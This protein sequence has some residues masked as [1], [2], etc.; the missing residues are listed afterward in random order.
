MGA[1]ATTLARSTM[2]AKVTM[3]ARDDTPDNM[4]DNIP[5]F[6]SKLQVQTSAPNFGSEL[7]LRTLAPNFSSELQPRTSAPNFSSQLQL[8]T[9]SSNCP[10][11]PLT[12]LPAPTIALSKRAVRQP[13]KFLSFPIVL[14]KVALTHST[15]GMPRTCMPY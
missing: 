4:L 14:H 15:C 1:K 3:R 6:S 7:R 9:S 2:R 8:Q 13:T 11:R 10:R 5:N 12:S